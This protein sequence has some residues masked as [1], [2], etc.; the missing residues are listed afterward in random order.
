MKLEYKVT[1]DA[2]GQRLDKFLRK[3]L[4][5]VPL[6]H[7][8]KLVRTKKVRVNGNRADI[9]RLLQEGD[10]VIVHAAQ[11]KPEGPPPERPA[12]A[13]PQ[14]FAILYEDAHILVCDKPAGLPIHP[15]TGINSDTLV[16]QARAYLERQGL[17]VP[18]GEFKPS[19]AHRIDRET[20]GVVV[21]A[22]TRQA[23]VR[24][25][26][27]FTAGEAKKTYLALAKG[28]FQ[29]DRGTIDVRLPEHQQT[30]ASKQV[31]GLNLQEAVTHFTKLSGGAEATL[32][33]LNIETGRTH[34]IRRHLAS[35]GHPVV[36]DAR[37]GDFAF[38]RR[39]RA[40]MGL[41]RMFL[42]S[43][44]LALLHPATGKRLAVSSPLPAEL[45]EALGRA[46]IAWKAPST[47]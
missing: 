12:S 43:T 7:L 4:S 22:K 38:N 45:T 40:S 17:E 15:G 1:E 33:E 39:A 6:S 32:L 2:A 36:G 19:P 42:H 23:M 8:Y 13:I 47:G 37:Y 34:Q 5:D 28:R 9:A 16:D 24:L 14:D 3:R 41:R 30:F 21:V 46:G 31:R 20:S 25:T 44:R 35:I 27:I 18:E 26:E 29:K 10:I 11:G